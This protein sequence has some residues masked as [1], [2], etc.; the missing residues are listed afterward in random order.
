MTG[1]L[2]NSV[3]P[4]YSSSEYSFTVWLT[5]LP[6][7]GKTTIGSSLAK[8]FEKKNKKCELLDG[9]ELRKIISSELGF[10]KK[11]RDL[12]LKRVT[13]LCQLLNRNGIIAIVAL[14]SPYRESRNYARSM[15]GNFVEVWVKCPLNICIERDP[16]GLYKKATDGKM[17]SLT[18]IQDPYEE[19]INP[20]IVLNTDTETVDT[21]T[22]RIVNYVENLSR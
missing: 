11:D 2:E 4:S 8:E 3:N 1:T 5:G 22:T 6:G 15:I 13:Y 20:E 7:S 18:G 19:P 21:S 17:N 10:T 14:I 12:H 16:K 9:D